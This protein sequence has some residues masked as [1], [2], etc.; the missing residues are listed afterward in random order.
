MGSEMCIRDRAGSWLAQFPS[1][2]E[3]LHRLTVRSDDRTGTRG[4]EPA[5]PV[6]AASTRVALDTLAERAPAAL[7]LLALCSWLAPLPLPLTLVYT[8][9]ALHLLRPHDASLHEPMLVDREVQ[10]LSRLGL[11]EVD[12]AGHTLKVH[13]IVQRL[14]LASLPANEVDEVRHEAHR[15]LTA[16]APRRD[17]SV[18]ETDD[19]AFERLWPHLDHAGADTCP[20]SDTRAVLLERVLSLIHI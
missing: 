11:A 17:D 9:T 18:A 19:L 13:R 15:L 7:R 8:D 10:E 20:D 4:D 1:A 12:Q 3:Y 14:V 2:H 6:I 16:A 5:F